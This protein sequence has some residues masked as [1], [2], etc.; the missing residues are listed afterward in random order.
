MELENNPNEKPFEGFANMKNAQLNNFI[1]QPN[2]VNSNNIIRK[3]STP[4]EV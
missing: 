4:M 3:N 2:G 1:R